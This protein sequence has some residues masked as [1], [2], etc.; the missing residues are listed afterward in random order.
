MRITR[1]VNE[2]SWKYA[3]GEVFLIVAGVSLALMANSW[4]GNW[5]EARYESQALLQISDALESDLEYLR[6]RFQD[7]KESEQILLALLGK[8]QSEVALTADS[9]GDFQSVIMWRGMR[10][11][12]GPYEELKN[13]GLSLVSDDMLRLSLID[14]YE[15]R[16][17]ALQGVTAN[18]QIFSRDQVLPFFYRTFRRVDFQRW[19]PIDGY[20]ELDNDLYFENLV[21]A[22]LDRL[23]GILLP[24]YEEFFQTAEGVLAQIRNELSN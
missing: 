3:V 23:Q 4:Y 13:R 10:V 20:E 18:D 1:L 12:S 14:L 15:N 8:L 7:L 6:A 11:R 24:A 22:K 19:S 5:Q 21:A 16:F 2:I 17:S 9:E